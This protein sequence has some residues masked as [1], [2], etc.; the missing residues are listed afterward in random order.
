MIKIGLSFV[1]VGQVAQVLPQLL[2]VDC[3]DDLFVVD[4]W[5]GPLPEDHGKGITVPFHEL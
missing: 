2:T 4:I 3:L 5:I 1:Q